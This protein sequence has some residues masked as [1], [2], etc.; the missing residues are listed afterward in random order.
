MRVRRS[1]AVLLAAL[2]LALTAGCGNAAPSEP[3]DLT[4]V[5][6]E[7]HGEGDTFHR[8]LIWADDMEIYWVDPDGNESLYW[9]GTFVPPETGGDYTWESEND[10]ERTEFAMMAS[11]SD[12]KEFHYQGGQITYQAS[13]LDT[14]WTVKLE[15]MSS[16]V[17]EREEEEN[18]ALPEEPEEQPEAEPLET[19]YG[20]GDTWTVDGQWELTVTDVYQV[21]P[22]P[23][24]EDPPAV[25]YQIDY[26]YTNLG[27]DNGTS[28]LNLNLLLGSIVDSEGM[29]GDAH[30]YI[31]YPDDVP[32]GATSEVSVSVG[33]DHPGTFTID[34]TMFDD[35]RNLHDALFRLEPSEAPV[36]TGEEPAQPPQTTE[37]EPAQTGG[38]VTLGELTMPLPDYAS[39]TEMEPGAVGQILLEEGKRQVTVIV[40]NLESFG[41]D[42]A[43]ILNKMMIGAALQDV[44][45]LSQDD[46]T[47]EVVGETAQVAICDVKM[48][49]VAQ[50]WTIVALFHNGNQYLFTYATTLDATGDGEDFFDMLEAATFAS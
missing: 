40:S 35:Q 49:D 42:D 20:V 36:T 18:A 9:A 12:T 3:P 26:T 22:G 31:E 38:T 47:M 5:W 29:M 6:E 11:T 1:L 46:Y 28:G 16:T 25:I 45:V 48:N 4:G 10:L 50:V 34:F 19:T 30:D 21:E 17:P 43:G 27:F 37:E 23:Y 39:Y 14:E 15:R 2:L 13:M 32:Q 33:L 7:E 41:A 24:E 44:N 8:A